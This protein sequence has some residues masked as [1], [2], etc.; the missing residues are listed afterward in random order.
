MIVL[1]LVKFVED[2]LIKRIDQHL[3]VKVTKR[4]NEI[5]KY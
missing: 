3:M 2:D 1:I 5:R 4:N